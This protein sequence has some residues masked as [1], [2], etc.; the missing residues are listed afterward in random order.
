M[1]VDCVR[2]FGTVVIK[3]NDEGTETLYAQQLGDAEDDVE[4]LHVSNDS[5]WLG[6]NHKVQITGTGKFKFRKRRTTTV[7]P[8]IT[9]GGGDS[10]GALSHSGF[11]SLSLLRKKH[12]R[13]YARSL[14][15]ALAT[16]K[17][18]DIWR[19]NSDDYEQESNDGLEAGQWVA[20]NS[21]IYLESGGK[22]GIGTD[23]T[24][25]ANT[26]LEIRATANPSILLHDSDATSTERI[27]EIRCHDE[28]F[29]IRSRNDD[30]T[31]AGNAGDIVTA[32]LTQGAF[33]IHNSLGVGTSAS[34]TVGEIRAT[35]EITAYYSDRRLKDVQGPILDALNK[36]DQLT[37]YRYKGNETA[38]KLGYTDDK[39]QVGL[40]A[41][42][43]QG[44]VPEA[45]T[46]API[47]INLDG[48][49]KSGENYLTIKYEKLIPLLVN[50]IKELRQ[51]VNDLKSKAENIPP[52]GWAS[53]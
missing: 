29:R 19:D 23:A 26:M 9:S 6:D 46:L 37:G 4:D 49:S 33:Q 5:I 18:K 38:V 30:N 45:V 1:A 8:V 3:T 36:V 15:G 13:A 21:D 43:V 44:V 14:G 50:A 27:I 28:A 34:G 17:N 53:I 39:Q 32:S 35:N 24:I 31:G 47:D 42:D 25:L 2:N 48:S 41:Q 12:W 40:M 51:E 52:S 11:G 22:V 16:A 10:A 20:S 7:P